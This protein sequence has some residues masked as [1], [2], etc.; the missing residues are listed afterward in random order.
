MTLSHAKLYEG[1]RFL[2]RG[3]FAHNHHLCVSGLI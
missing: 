1:Q 3:L 2:L